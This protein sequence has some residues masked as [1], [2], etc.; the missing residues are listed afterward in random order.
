LLKRRYGFV[1]LAVMLVLTASFQIALP[2]KAAASTGIEDGFETVMPI[3][4]VDTV[5]AKKLSY[6]Y[7]LTDQYV[8][9]SIDLAIQRG[10]KVALVGENGAGK[11]TFVKLVSGMLYPSDGML[12]VNGIP[13]EELLPA[14]RERYYNE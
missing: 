6:R 10:E 8:L 12:L 1:L 5:E 9:R 4:S 14:S 11:T 7:P 3:E 2:E 13:V